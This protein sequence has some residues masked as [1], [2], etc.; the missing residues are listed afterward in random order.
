MQFIALNFG[1]ACVLSLAL[2]SIGNLF[3]LFALKRLSLFVF[4][5]S[6]ALTAWA[7]TFHR[8][9]DARQV[10]LSLG[11]RLAMAVVLAL[12]TLALWRLCEGF[13]PTPADLFLSIGLCSSGAFWLDRKSRDWL[14]LTGERILAGFRTAVIEVS[15]TEPHPDKLTAAFEQL[16]R[17]RGQTA[18]AAVLFDQGETHAAG[19]LQLAKRTPGHAALCAYGWA[20]PESLQRLRSTPPLADLRRFVLKHTLGLVVAVPSGSP[21][22]SLLV[23]LGTKTNQWPFTYPEVQRLQNIAELMDSILTRARLASQAA[24]KARLEHLA[25]MSR[26]LAHDLNNLITPVSSFLVHTDGRFAPGSAEQEVHAA[27]KHSVRV[28]TEYVREALFFANRLA[29]KFEIIQLHELFELVRDVTA[30]LAA[31]H[32]VAIVVAP[33]NGITLAIDAVLVQRVLVNV[34][35]NAIDASPPR[36]KVTLSADASRPG[37][38]R[39]QVA[40][41]GCGISPE[42]INRVF[43][44]YFTTKEFGDETRGFGLGLTICQ[45]IVE[46]HEGSISIQSQPGCGTILIVDLPVTQPPRPPRSE[47][48]H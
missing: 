41:E 10:F 27:A 5:G 1:T 40:D 18:F 23:A 36:S 17:E 45:K 15:C 31:R 38:V 12:C 11:Q 35:S 2:A 48:A 16:L 46:L 4:A 19:N 34:I 22:P 29:P 32:E 43:D 20:T 47:A 25:I 6:Y 39:L 26:G 14:G 44:P 42:N 3:H 24:M 13:L 7:I 8:V 28:M 21:T 37:R 9:F 30:P 33:A